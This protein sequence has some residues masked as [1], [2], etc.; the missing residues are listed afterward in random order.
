MLMVHL[1]HNEGE[2]F[3]QK[4]LR[5]LAAGCWRF[6]DL[7]SIWKLRCQKDGGRNALKAAFWAQNKSFE[8]SMPSKCRICPLNV[9]SQKIFCDGDL[10]I[11][12]P[13]LDFCQDSLRKTGVLRK[14]SCKIYSSL[15]KIHHIR[16]HRRSQL[17]SH[18]MRYRILRKHSVK[19]ALMS[20]LFCMTKDC[21]RSFYLSYLS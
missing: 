12:I 9:I 13:T 20:W 15:R 17:T 4:S 8:E 1:Y 21:K 2:K 11:L 19:T 18:V 3:P 16:S 5:R 10:C 6:C 14:E 7:W